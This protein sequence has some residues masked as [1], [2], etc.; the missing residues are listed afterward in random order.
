VN[1]KKFARE[2]FKKFK[3]KDCVRVNTSVE[4]KVKMSKN[5][6][7]EKIKSTT[8]KSLVEN[9][10]Y[11][12]WTHL[13]ILF[14]VGLVSRFIET[15]TMTHFKALKLILRYIKGTVDFGLFYVYSNS[16]ELMGYSDSD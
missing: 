5:D 11:L 1:Q 9:L 2:V 14:E 16:F 10:R 8:F 15:P 7:W 12:T 13:D 3:I 6:E 4:C